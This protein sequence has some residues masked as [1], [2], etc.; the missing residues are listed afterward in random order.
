MTRR[1]H[2][3]R[4]RRLALVNFSLPVKAPDGTYRG[5]LRSVRNYQIEALDADGNSLGMFDRFWLAREAVEKAA[6][7]PS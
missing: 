3:R 7:V 6:K 5:E 4:L 1:D 2:R